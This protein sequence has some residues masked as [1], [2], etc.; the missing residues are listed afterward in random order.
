MND[1]R[2]SERARPL[3]A[4]IHEIAPVIRD[5]ADRAEREARL[6]PEV[7]EAFHQ[8]ELFRILLPREFGGADVTIPDSLRLCEEVSAID[9]S[10]G[11][12]L[13]I[14]ASSA[15]FTNCLSRAAFEKIYN[16]P[17][18][19]GCGSLNPMTSQVVRK[20]EGWC[21]NGRATYA[22]GS[23]QSNWLLAAPLVLHDGAPRFVDGVPELRA[24][25]FP[26]SN[27]KILDT[28]HMTGMSGTGSNDCVFENV[29]VADEFTFDWLN[30]QPAWRGQAYQT[31][32]LPLQFV[33]NL[34]CVLLGIARHAL[35]ELKQIARIKVPVAT[36]GTLRE[37][38]IAQTQVA[39]A[40]GL[41]Q[42]ARAWFYNVNEEIWRRGLAGD[43]FNLEDR[44][45]ARLASVTAT[46]LALQAIDLVADAAGMNANQTANPISRCWRDAHTASQHVLLNTARFEVIGRVMFGLDPDSPVI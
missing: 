5:N 46:K 4:R 37:R 31:I 41:L 13:A 22:S 34:A 14:C 30:S 15:L 1:S 18:A 45:T 8:T 12:N 43:S 23:A 42:A 3:L 19:V 44:A 27:A 24:G 25:F 29:I 17:R 6:A 40:E 10:T 7:V 21:F 2:L 11:W 16:D 39:Q 33:G 36:R 9:G 35:D 38:P 28:W 26:M 20:N 32:P